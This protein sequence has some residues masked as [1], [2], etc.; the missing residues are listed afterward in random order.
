MYTTRLS[1]PAPLHAV[2]PSADNEALSAKEQTTWLLFIAL[3]APLGLW[4]RSESI[5]VFG[6]GAIVLLLGLWWA[7]NTRRPERVAY[8]AAYIVG[9]EV[10][11]RM[12]TDALPWES[13]K[14][15]IGRA[16]CRERV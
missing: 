14:Y 10:L 4:M 16:S 9:S 1:T 5:I 6:Q 15:E 11:W 8:L 7:L 2:A 12:I 3:H 13:G